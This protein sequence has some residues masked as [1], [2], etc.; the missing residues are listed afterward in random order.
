MYEHLEKIGEGVR[1][2]MKSVLST[3]EI[4]AQVT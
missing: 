4:R 1:S 2:A 3:L